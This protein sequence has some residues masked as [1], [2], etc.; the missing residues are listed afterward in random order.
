MEIISDYTEDV[1]HKFGIPG[2]YEWWYFDGISDNGYS[3]VVI[4]YEGNPFSRKYI[5]ALG[6]DKGV[7]GEDYPAI[8]I[9]LY[10]NGKAIFYSF[11][12][13]RRDEA[14]FSDSEPSGYVGKNRFDLI[15]GE[16]PDTLAYRLILDQVLPN[17]DRLSGQIQ[18]VSNRGVS[19]QGL[20]MDQPEGDSHSWNLVQPKC[21]VNG[22]LNVEGSYQ[23]RINFQGLGYHDHNSGIEPMKE[24]FDE[25][26]WGRYHF[27]DFTVI[28]YFMNEGESWNKKVWILPDGGMGE[29]HQICDVA[30]M[31]DYSMNLFG[32][33]CARKVVVESNEIR[34]LIQKERVTDSGPFY[35][36][37]EGTMLLN[38]GDRLYRSKGISEYIKPDR[39]YSRIFWPLVDM[40]IK[41]P[42]KPHWVQKSSLLYR[43]TW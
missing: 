16:N 29:A 17:G 2:G 15:G 31:S 26:Y 33:T 25:W 36:R 6:N 38:M 27:E 34:L 43:W 9:S 11:E 10:K 19:L 30:E 1:S 37:F 8:S 4:F 14:F 28:C 5:Q 40:R 42:G 7:T 39:I 23:D 21:E 18:F 12:E 3:I 24:Q 32:L 35:K 41:Y 20:I 22:L 13:V